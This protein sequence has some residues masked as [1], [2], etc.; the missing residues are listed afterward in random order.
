MTT[1]TRPPSNLSPAEARLYRATLAARKA[2]A[3]LH[4][5]QRNFLDAWD[6]RSPEERA[7]ALAPLF[8]AEAIGSTAVDGY[9]FWSDLGA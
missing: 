2:W 1:T 9:V 3:A 8:N 6:A 5:A 4:A 7:R